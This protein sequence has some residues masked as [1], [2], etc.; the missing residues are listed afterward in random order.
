L[1]A[2]DRET[3]RKLLAKMVQEFTT[4][5]PKAIERLEAGFE[6]ALER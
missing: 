2:P 6:D 5:V 4:V 3:A 1:D